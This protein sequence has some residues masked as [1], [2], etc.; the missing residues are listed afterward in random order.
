LEWIYSNKAV[1]QAE[2]S[3]LWNCIF[4]S[5]IPAHS[6]PMCPDLWHH[7]FGKLWITSSAHLSDYW[8]NSF[9]KNSLDRHTC[10]IFDYFSYTVTVLLN[11]I[12]F[13]MQYL[14]KNKHS[15]FLIFPWCQSLQEARLCSAILAL[16]SVCMTPWQFIRNSPCW[17]VLSKQYS[18][19]YFIDFFSSY[20]NWF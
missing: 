19:V 7:Q 9:L 17:I 10:M 18:F 13:M 20:L 14:K 8:I 2:K 12:H 15:S 11:V 3:A 16:I 5:L 6:S 4:Q 1:K